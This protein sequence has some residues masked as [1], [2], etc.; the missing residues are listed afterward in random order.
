MEYYHRT[1]HMD[2]KDSFLKRGFMGPVPLMAK[3]QALFLARHLLSAP[4][5]QVWHKPLAAEDPLVYQVA[6]S[7][8]L[9]R[10]LRDLIG[11]DIVLWGG[12]IA[13]KQPGE[14]HPWHCDIESCGPSGGFVSVWIGLLN[15]SKESSLMFVRGSHTYAA[16]IQE[17]S[18]R[19]QVSRD[20]MT[21]EIALR[22]ANSQRPGAEIVQ[23]EVNDGEAIIFDGRIW[24][25]SHNPESGKPRVSLLLQYARADIA[26]KVPD[27]SNLKWPF[28]F[29]EDLRQSVVAVAGHTDRGANDLLPPPSMRLDQP[30]L[31]SAHLIAPNLRCKDGVSFASTPCFLGHTDNAEYLEC[32]YSVLMP[33]G[34]PHSPHAHLEE[35]ILVVMRGSAELIVPNSIHD[36]NPQIFPAPTGTAI[37][38]PSYQPHTIRNRSAQ[39][40]CY[41]MI[42]WKSPKINAA[43]QLKPQLVQSTWVQKNALPGTGSQTLLLEGATTF[44]DKL[45]AHVTRFQPGGGYAAHR[46]SHDVAIFLIR[47]QIAILGNCITVPAVVFLPAR[48]LHDMKATGTEMAK[49]LVWEFHKNSGPGH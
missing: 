17:V 46:D 7:P 44:L 11:G 37:Y 10:I 15:T 30:I 31:P 19:N 21:D 28:L 49:Y 48:C 22:M 41:A 38:Y 8:E 13:R 36:G 34:C 26:V 5:R 39:P 9:L 2:K 16:V 12:S 4:H 33:G 32:H 20:E 14:I 25:G 27:F 43:E 1:S 40:V 35:E 47:G 45:H 23:P 18:A 3:G 24:H 42:K 29:R 6:S